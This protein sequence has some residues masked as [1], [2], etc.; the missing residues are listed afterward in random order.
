M[1]KSELKKLIE[2]IVS[3]QIIKGKDEPKP[4]NIPAHTEADINKLKDFIDRTYGPKPLWWV[5]GMIYDLLDRFFIFVPLD[6]HLNNGGTNL[7]E[8]STKKNKK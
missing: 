2:E 6:I 4:G 1:K 7:A 8:H 5:T 3:E